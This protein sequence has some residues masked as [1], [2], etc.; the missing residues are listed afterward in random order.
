ME[1]K[2]HCLSGGKYSLLHH[3]SQAAL[4]PAA[5]VCSGSVAHS[6]ASEE[7]APAV[8]CGVQAEL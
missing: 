6:R 7:K 5:N 4:I 3:V 2:C 1:A 8:F